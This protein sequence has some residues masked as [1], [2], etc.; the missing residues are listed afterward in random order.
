MISHA[1]FE[2]IPADFVVLGVVPEHAVD[3]VQFVVA[4][5]EH[6][7]GMPAKPPDD[8]DGLF[9]DFGEESPVLG[10]G[11]AGESLVLPDHDAGLVAKIE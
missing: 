4:R 1:P 6:E 10:I 5:P 2:D 7:R 8:L 11:R 9:S 3:F